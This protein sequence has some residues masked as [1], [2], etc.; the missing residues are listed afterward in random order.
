MVAAMLRRH[1]AP[2]PDP[3]GVEDGGGTLEE[4]FK[5]ARRSANAVGGVRKRSV[6][7][8]FLHS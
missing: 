8:A 3:D 7:R 4:R 2:Y 5:P 1:R 6:M